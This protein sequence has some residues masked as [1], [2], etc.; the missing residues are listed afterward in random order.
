M[1]PH[2]QAHI[3]S[4]PVE[5]HD[6]LKALSSSEPAGLLQVSA[7]VDVDYTEGSELTYL[8]GV[9]IDEATQVPEDLDVIDVR[10][11]AWAVF[12][13]TRTYPD[14][15]QDSYAA[16]ASDWFPSNPWRLRDGPSI[17]SIIDRADDFSTATTELW[18]PVERA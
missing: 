6:R 9:A 17:V 10:A 12:R 8:H 15:M 16:A 2:I 3:A 5:E 4:L 13:T 14:A 11:G 18:V 7:D 1:N